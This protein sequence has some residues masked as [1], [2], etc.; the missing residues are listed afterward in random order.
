MTVEDIPQVKQV[1]IKSWHTT[2]ENI[3]P[4]DVQNNFLEK[5]YSEERL[6]IRLSKSPF[7]VAKLNNKIIGF[8]NFSNKKLDGNVELAAIYLSKDFQHQG[9]GTKLLQ[10][11]IY[12][13]RPTQI[14]INVE[15]EN[16]I[17]RQFYEAKGFQ[18]IDQFDEEFDGHILKT[19][20]MAL[21]L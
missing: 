16:K 2:Y 9:V 15:A 10:F 18:I 14:F 20:R 21:N 3:I 7:Y 11:G 6:L 12:Q 4:L 19:I 8:A 13:L 1:A 5:A 17:G